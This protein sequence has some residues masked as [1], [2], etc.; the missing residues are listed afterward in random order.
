MQDG[1][2]SARGPRARLLS[3]HLHS[4]LGAAALGLLFAA[5]GFARA[6]SAPVRKPA[7]KASSST[8]APARPAGDVPLPPPPVGMT[9]RERPASPVW[10][11][12]ASFGPMFS[13]GSAGTSIG[14]RLEAS[15]PLKPLSP[16][17]E[18]Q[19]FIPFTF[20]YW[21]RTTSLAIPGTI[22]SPPMSATTEAK[23]LWFALVPSARFAFR[24]PGAPRLGL[25]ADGGLGITAGL[26]KTTTDQTFNGRN[27]TA[28][29]SVGAVV[30]L[31]GGGSYA[32]NDKI[33]ITLEPIGLDF[34][35]A[36]GSSTWS[37]LVGAAY[38]L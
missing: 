9:L 22:F 17:V 30:R 6:Q 12:G 18:L 24:V 8:V 36:S 10:T 5:P 20:A 35:I 7:A 33:R 29:N 11:A 13:L 31:A 34:H 15:R 19:L 32:V 27:T 37:L 28:D 4:V 14:L 16:T 25:Y 23:A 1:K 2:V 3:R 26:A 21:G 38:L